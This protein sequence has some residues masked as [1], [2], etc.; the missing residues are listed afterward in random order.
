MEELISIILEVLILNKKDMSVEEII[1]ICGFQKTE[2][3]KSLNVIIDTG[4]II[5]NKDE[6]NT[7]YHIEKKLKGINVAKAAQLGIDIGAFEFFFEIDKKEKELALEL[8]TQAEKIKDLV[9]SKRK[10]LLQKRNYLNSHKS[11]DIYENLMLLFEASN[12]ALYSYLEDCAKKD[13]YLILL[14]NMHSQAENSLRDYTD[15]LK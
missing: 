14:L 3:I 12:M 5:K 2:V 15:Y 7:T 10:P 1:E 8:A 6:H 9:V 4:I 11:D 13:E